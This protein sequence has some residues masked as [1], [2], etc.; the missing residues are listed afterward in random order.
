MQSSRE[1]WKISWQEFSN[2]DNCRCP[3]VTRECC[4]AHCRLPLNRRRSLRKPNVSTKYPRFDHLIACA[5]LWCHV[6]WKLNVTRYTLCI[7]FDMILPPTRFCANF[8]S[9]CI[10]I[11]LVLITYYHIVW[12]DYRRSLDWWLDLLTLIHSRH[13]TAL[14]RSLTHRLVSSVYDSLH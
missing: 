14:C 10:H 6:L 3:D 2:R 11:Q 13:V 12:S 9:S 5:I 7:I 1:L 8:V 4:K